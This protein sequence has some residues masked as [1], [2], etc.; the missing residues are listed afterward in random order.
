MKVGKGMEAWQEIAAQAEG[1]QP[2]QAGEAKK[3]HWGSY[4]GNRAQPGI[5]PVDGDKLVLGQR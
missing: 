5:L 4:L 3:G 1:A 2:E